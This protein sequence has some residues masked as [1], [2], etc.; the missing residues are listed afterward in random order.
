MFSV[1]IGFHKKLTIPYVKPSV[2]VSCLFIPQGLMVEVAC[3]KNGSRCLESVWKNLTTGQ[4][5]RIAEELSATE[6][7]RGDKFGHFL[8]YNFALGKF[9]NQ[10]SQ[11]LHIQGAQ[12]KRKKALAHLL[13]KGKIHKYNSL[14]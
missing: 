4:R 8:F 9:L 11:W 13:N 7:L 14:L 10:R 5:T 1:N 3:S 12:S 2:I 6:R